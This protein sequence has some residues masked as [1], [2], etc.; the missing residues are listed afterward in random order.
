LVGYVQ[1]DDLEQLDEQ[2][3]TS[4]VYRGAVGPETILKVN[5]ALA[6]ALGLA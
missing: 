6:I 5:Q 4:A 3:L 1:A 2:D